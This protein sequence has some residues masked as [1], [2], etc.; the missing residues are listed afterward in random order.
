MRENSLKQISYFFDRLWPILRS[1]T[2][3]GV[4]K[5]HKILNE[6][7]P[8]KT[9]EIPSGKKVHDWIV[10]KEWKLIDAYIIDPSGKKICDVK[11]NNLHVINYSVSVNKTLTLNELQKYLHSI[12]KLPNAIPYLTSYYGNN[13]GFCIEH[14]LRSKLKPGKYKVFI[15]SRHFNGS[16]TISEKVLKGKTKKEILFTTYTCHPS[17]ANNELSGPLVSAFLYK[18]ILKLKNRYFTY[19]F[20]FHPETIGSI[21]YLSKKGR[22]LKNNVF[23]AYNLTCLGLKGSPIVYKRSRIGNSVSDF[24]AEKILKKLKKNN[25]ITK[26]FYPFGSDERQYC[27][28]GYNLPMGVI[29]RGVPGKY[30]QYHTSLDNKKLISMQ[31]LNEMIKIYYE[32]CKFLENNKNKIKIIK[33]HIKINYKK[34]N[35][36]C[37]LNMNPYCE[38][39]LT[40]RNLQQTIGSLRDRKID[41]D[42]IK[43]L[44]NFSDGFHDIKSIAKKSGINANFLKKKAKSC[45]KLGLLKKL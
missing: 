33:N 9:L 40:K 21:A 4:R 7:I 2:G 24:A 25:F 16:M 18:K 38:P 12:K 10:P 34:K 28:P 37:F 23:A 8:L 44:L 32:I 15:N 3:D 41:I 45:C 42:A 26:D 1:I 22:Y 35:K 36:N 31:V 5:T 6:L 11:K 43:W 13:W 39:H 29:M 19:R 17:M 14:K 20:V 27:S 30:K